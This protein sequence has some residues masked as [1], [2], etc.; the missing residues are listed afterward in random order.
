[1]NRCGEAQARWLRLLAD[2]EKNT[3]GVVIG[4]VEHCGRLALA[5]PIAGSMIKELEEVWET[6]LVQMLKHELV[7]CV[8]YVY[9]L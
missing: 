3:A 4:D 5:L 7:R 8:I 6:E 1:M 9:S 2:S